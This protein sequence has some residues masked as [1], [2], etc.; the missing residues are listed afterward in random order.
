MRKDKP[1]R[2][3]HKN[4]VWCRGS[5]RSKMLFESESKANNFIKFNAKTI[6]E[7]SGMAPT[8]AY[9]CQFCC[10]WHVTKRPE[11]SKEYC[12]ARD[13]EK[14]QRVLGLGPSPK[15]D[16][17]K[18]LTEL[19]TS[20]EIDSVRVLLKDEERNPDHDI[21]ETLRWLNGE[22]HDVW[23]YKA[24]QDALSNQ[25]VW[26]KTS[27]LLKEAEDGLAEMNVQKT[28]SSLKE[29]RRL[30]GQFRGSGSVSLVKEFSERAK[31]IDLELAELVPINDIW[32]LVD[33]KSILEYQELQ[34]TINNILK[35]LASWDE[36][37]EEPGKAIKNCG[38]RLI[39]R[40]GNSDI[41]DRFKSL[42]L[43]E[44]KLP[45]A[46]LLLIAWKCSR[47][48][49]LRIEYKRRAWVVIDK[50]QSPDGIYGRLHL[51]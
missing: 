41:L 11:E 39:G 29:A 8:R 35:F 38:K 3:E 51:V 37:S 7:E 46:A 49:E 15:P 36:P 12:D 23:R 19:L 21:Q 33:G 28:E 34:Q 9:Y 27:G 25:V 45:K 32:E 48:K 5:G 2:K 4:S 22:E 42:I 18:T 26:I 47:G 44:N 17:K 6:L 43:K 13:L 16:I 50:D 31:E 14:L 24:I 30:F 40:D 20:L 1:D 10:G